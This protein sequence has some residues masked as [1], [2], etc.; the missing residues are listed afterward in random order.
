M[1]GIKKGR[2]IV[3]STLFHATAR[4]RHATLLR[5]AKASAI[6]FWLGLVDGLLVVPAVA[7]DR[8]IH[9][10]RTAAG[11]AGLAIATSPER[12]AAPR[13]KLIDLCRSRTQTNV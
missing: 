1:F 10:E 6:P 7:A 4:R 3:V 5:H 8:L 12:R 13:G 9:G 2:N 11:R